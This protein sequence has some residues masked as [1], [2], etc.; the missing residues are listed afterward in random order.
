MSKKNV[1]VCV[2]WPYAN[3]NLHLGYIASSLSGDILSRYHRMHGDRVL[4]ISGSDSHGTKLE[5]KAKQLGCSPKEIVDQY[6]QNF[7]EALK[8]FDFS[9]DKFGITYDPY[10]MEKCQEIFKKLYNNGYLYEKINLRPFCDKCNK[11]I[12]D[13]EIEISCPECG[14]RTKA[15]NCDC[16]YVPT[17]KDLEGGKCLICGGTTHQKENKV[18]VFKLSA[19]KNFLTENVEKNRTYW[20]NN[21]INE[22]E[23]YLKDLQDRDFSR[24]L[25]WGVKVPIEG[26]EDKAVWVWYEALLGY[27]TQCM[28]LSEKEG[29]D[30]ED[31]WKTDHDTN[32]EKLIYMCHAKDNIPFHS[33]FFPAMLEGL[34]E[35]FVTPNRMVSAEYL[36]MNN[37]KISKSKSGN[38]FEALS[39]ANEY[40]TDTL[41]YFF[42]VNGPEKKDCNFSLDLYK[43]CHN[44]VV[45]KFGNLVNRTLKYKGLTEIPLGKV[46]ENIKDAIATTY[47]NV[48]LEIENIE[49]K[50]A[51]SLV[52]DL[53]ELGNK[54]FDER[55]PWVQIKEDENGFADTIYTCAYL[56]ANLSNLIEPFMPKSAGTLREYLGITK[57]P[58]W[59]EI[60]EFKTKIDIEKIQPLFTRI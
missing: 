17:E 57:T 40:N 14:K 9:F 47:K 48:G 5:L 18:L 46:D 1:V 12:A 20:R 44:E 3:N 36:L 28:E 59:E 56:I 35:N 10:H 52:M 37:E 13:T 11:F 33:L 51:G 25:E 34:H 24:D 54:Y 6:H 55:K 16:G 32:S 23:K 4:M 53:I 49:F 30:W 39:W 29:F 15:D 60:T 50:K 43:T 26:F 21:S 41:R 31:F 8:K 2:S 45:N 58:S 42:T 19:F 22:T 7:V 27:L 38:S